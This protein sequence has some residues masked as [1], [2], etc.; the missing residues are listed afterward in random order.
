AA[1]DASRL[2]YVA[3]TRAQSQVVAWWAP[4][5]DEPNGGLSRLLRGRAPG[6]PRRTSYSGLLRAAEESGVSSE[7]E[8]AELDDEVDEI[9][10]RS[11]PAGAD[12]PSPMAQLPAG[13][14]FGS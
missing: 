11:M 10:L 6:N 7:P 5:F 8:I 4:S 2:A 13:A 12:V 9:P 3:L 14:A 1:R